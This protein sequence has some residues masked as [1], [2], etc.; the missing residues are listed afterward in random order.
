M[1]DVGWDGFNPSASSS[2]TK[3]DDFDQFD[4]SN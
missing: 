3:V 2:V 1:N 4:Q